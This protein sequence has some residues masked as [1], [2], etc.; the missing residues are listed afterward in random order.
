[1]LFLIYNNRFQLEKLLKYQN[2]YL[3]SFKFCKNEIDN[4]TA[5]CFSNI[6][7]C[8]NNTRDKCV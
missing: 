1:M 4:K 5:T 8:S 7:S 2:E 6:K 3:N